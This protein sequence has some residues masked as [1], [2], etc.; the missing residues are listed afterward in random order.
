MYEYMATRTLEKI[1]RFFDG[2][3]S[4]IMGETI[5]EE[6]EPEGEESELQELGN[7]DDLSEKFIQSQDLERYLDIGIGTGADDSEWFRHK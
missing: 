3:Q 6:A 2:G 4:A 5:V 7:W 1:I